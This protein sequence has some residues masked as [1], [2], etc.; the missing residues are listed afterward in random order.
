MSGAVVLDYTQDKVVRYIEEG[1][2]AF[3]MKAGFERSSKKKLTKKGG[4]YLTIPFRWATPNAIGE[5]SVFNAR[6]PV[7][8]HD[9]A[10][11]LD[12]VAIELGDIP[13]KYQVKKARPSITNLGLKETFNEYKHKTNIYQGVSRRR[14]TDGGSTYMSF[15]RVSSNSD[16]MS[17]IH[18]G[19]N[20]YNLAD[21]AKATLDRNFEDV[22]GIAIDK[23]LD[24]LGY[25]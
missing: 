3:D 12:G 8:I 7:S 9:A 14:D 24:H 13:A 11:K 15:R 5:S 10:K 4:W 23:A 20:A 16:D 21:D 19:I 2:G 1:V 22:C 17:W 25:E 18:T 6:L